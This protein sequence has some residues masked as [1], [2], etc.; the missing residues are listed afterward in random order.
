VV[1]LE[2]VEPA[3]SV[4]LVLEQVGQVGDRHVTRPGPVAPDSQ[5]RLLSHDPAREQRGRRLSEHLGHL[6]LDL[7]DRALLG[8]HVP[9]VD[10]QLVRGVGHRPQHLRRLAAVVPEDGRVA[11]LRRGFEAFLELVVHAGQPTRRVAA[12]TNGVRD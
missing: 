7:S 12:T 11:G 1:E 8:V 2:P 4:V 5:D 10:A 9:F 6:A 3:R